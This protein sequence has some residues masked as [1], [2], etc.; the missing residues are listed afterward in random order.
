MWIC[1]RRYT[2]GTRL[3]TPPLTRSACCVRYATLTQ[4]SPFVVHAY[5]VRQV[6]RRR[7]EGNPLFAFL[8]APPDDPDA[9]YYRWRALSLAFGDRYSPALSRPLL[10]NYI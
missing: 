9:L 3:L 10:S 1:Q 7:E 2:E 4:P 8:S 6:I 5:T